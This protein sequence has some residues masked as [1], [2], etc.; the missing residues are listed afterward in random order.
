MVKFIHFYIHGFLQFLWVFWTNLFNL[1]ATLSISFMQIDYII[2]KFRVGLVVPLA[3]RYILNLKLTPPNTFSFPAVLLG[4]K[5]LR[6]FPTEIT[7][8]QLV[9]SK[10]WKWVSKFTYNK[11]LFHFRQFYGVIEWFVYWHKQD[12]CSLS[13]E[14]FEHLVQNLQTINIFFIFHCFTGMLSDSFI[15]R[16]QMNAASPE[17]NLKIRLKTYRR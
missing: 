3:C 6:F 9:W 15:G 11:Y 17:K 2:R 1:K 5:V 8:I 16:N 14:K 4:Y 12:E 7:W 10:I 13:R